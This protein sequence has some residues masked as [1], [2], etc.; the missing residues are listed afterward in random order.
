MKKI[1]TIVA[2]LL[3]AYKAPI[4]EVA[5]RL[6]PT[7]YAIE[8]QRYPDEYFFLNGKKYTATN[9][10]EGLRKNKGKIEGEVVVHT[11]NHKTS[12]SYYYGQTPGTII[13]K[14]DYYGYGIIFVDESYP[15]ETIPAE[16]DNGV[17][18]VKSFEDDNGKMLLTDI[19][20]ADKSQEALNTFPIET[21]LPN[22]QK[23]S[24][25]VGDRIKVWFYHFTSAGA[26]RFYI[27][28]YKWDKLSQ[29]NPKQDSNNTSSR[30]KLANSIYNSLIQSNAAQIL[31]EKSPKTIANIKPSLE[32]LM[33][34]TNV[35]ME[36]A[37]N[38]FLTDK[39][40]AEG[41]KDAAIVKIIQYKYDKKL[42]SMSD[43]ELAKSIFQN[44]IMTNAGKM[45]LEK[46]PKTVKSI[47]KELKEKVESSE[48]L[49]EDAINT[50]K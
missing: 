36:E 16:V 40:K 44:V 34:E 30:S 2:L 41:N 42:E 23:D 7:S 46:T 27:G 8:G 33:G 15:I 39:D 26:D 47:E 37:Y 38:V 32:K 5:T 22:Y 12:R 43:Q 9:Y 50:L 28:T 21:T 19:T 48:K 35:L 45:L 18:E 13:T 1:L 6:V 49:V 31:L 25:K 11:N 3:V 4:K 29:A 14:D 24:L 10:L 17:F 20:M